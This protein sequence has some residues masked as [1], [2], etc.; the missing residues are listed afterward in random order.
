METVRPASG[1]PRALQPAVVERIISEVE[2]IR[3]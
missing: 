3:L 1:E 2:T